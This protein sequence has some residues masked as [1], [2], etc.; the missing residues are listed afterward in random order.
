MINVPEIR[1]QVVRYLQN[2]ITLADL[3]DWLTQR[4]WN[5]HLDS[6]LDAQ[7]LAADVELLLA[8][9]SLGHLSP[10]Q[11]QDALNDLVRSSWPVAAGV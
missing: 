5:M 1:D 4:S 2:Q 8:E 10:E 9:Y 7:R 6:P 11:L 3:N